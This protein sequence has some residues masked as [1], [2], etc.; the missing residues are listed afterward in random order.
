MAGVRGCS[1]QCCVVARECAPADKEARGLF[2]SI[3]WAL[4]ALIRPYYCFVDLGAVVAILGRQSH[5]GSVYLGRDG[6]HVRERLVGPF[7]PLI[8]FN[9]GHGVFRNQE[10]QRTLSGENGGSYEIEYRTIGIEDGI[11]R[12]VF[13]TGNVIFEQGRAVRFTGTLIDIT[14]RKKAERHLHILNDT[15]AAASPPVVVEELPSFPRPSLF[16]APSL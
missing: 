4:I 10:V 3:A 8:E 11:E 5:D 1:R 12:W 15:G 9:P 7:P 6:R 16:A 14:A 13:A 2:T